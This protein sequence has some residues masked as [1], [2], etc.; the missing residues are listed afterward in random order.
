MEMLLHG[1]LQKEGPF[2]R[3]THRLRLGGEVVL[4][5]GISD[6]ADWDRN[7]ELLFAKGG[8]LYR[9]AGPPWQD[10]LAR[11]IADFTGDRFQ[12]IAAPP[13]ALKWPPKRRR[14]PL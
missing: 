5:L 11:E 7:G 3:I 12:E 1:A 10:A 6:W 14:K 9:L 13:W 8:K 4:E 2:Y